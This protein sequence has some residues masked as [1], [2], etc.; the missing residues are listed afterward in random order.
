MDLDVCE[1]IMSRVVITNALVEEHVGL[2]SQHSR[3]TDRAHLHA[4]RSKTSTNHSR[5]V[6]IS[7]ERLGDPGRLSMKCK[8]SAPMR[9]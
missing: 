4:V 8:A 9:R 2:L 7:I 6:L 3:Q 1:S 5:L